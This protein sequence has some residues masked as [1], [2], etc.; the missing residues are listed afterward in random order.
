[1]VFSGVG[2]FAEFAGNI[3]SASEDD[4]EHEFVCDEDLFFSSDPRV[5]KSG[6]F[7]P[8]IA[9]AFQTIQSD[10]GCCMWRH[11]IVGED[12]KPR[13]YTFLMSSMDDEDRWNK[14]HY[15]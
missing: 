2:S 11:D 1:M 15:D 8:C 9:R 10:Q 3:L 13:H 7:P 5:W 6:S 12:K 14:V 4:D